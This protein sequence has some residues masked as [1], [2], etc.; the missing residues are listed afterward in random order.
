MRPS[1]RRGKIRWA[2]KSAR[3]RKLRPI[4]GLHH[5]LLKRLFAGYQSLML[6]HAIRLNR[7]FS[8]V[9]PHGGPRFRL[10]GIFAT[11]LWRNICPAARRQG[12]SPA[13][14]LDSAAHGCDFRVRARFAP[15]AAVFC[16]RKSTRPHCL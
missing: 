4:V 9:L 8:A 12:F 13:V 11:A 6:V 2:L 7:T 16:A 5:A 10:S 14:P 15:A 1:V 3:L